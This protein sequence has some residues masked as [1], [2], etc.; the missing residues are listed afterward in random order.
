VRT[1][2]NS[3]AISV[4]G[5]WRPVSTFASLIGVASG[6]LAG[7][8]ANPFDPVWR[9]Q[10]AHGIVVSKMNLKKRIGPVAALRKSVKSHG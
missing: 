9:A 6:R 1:S 10:N 2:A 8:D 3:I 4:I 5:F 7:G